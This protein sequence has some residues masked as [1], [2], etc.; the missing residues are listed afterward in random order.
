M[1]ILWFFL[2]IFSQQLMAENNNISMTKMQ[3]YNLG[4][5]TEQLKEI[6]QIPLLQVSAEVVVPPRQEFIISAPQLGLVNKLFVAIGDE[7]EKLQILATI[8]S[9]E[10]LTLQRQFLKTNGVKQLAWAAYKRDKQLFKEGVIADRQWQASRA[11]YAARLVEEDEAEQL[12]V[13]AGMS[14][15][16]IEQ[17]AA[18][19]QL[20]SQ[21]NIYSPVKGVVLERMVKMGE[22]LTM[23]TPLYRI[24]NLEQLW[25][26]IDVPQANIDGVQQGNRV[27]I[28]NT[29]MTATISLIGKNVNKQM[30]TVLV[31]AVIDSQQTNLRVGQRINVK[32]AQSSSE[33]VFIVPEAAIVNNKRQPYIFVRNEAGVRPTSIHI[34][35]EQEGGMIVTG[36]EVLSGDVNIVVRGAIALKAAWLG[37]NV[38]R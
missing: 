37:S 3:L 35:G 23:F 27:V 8:K 29:E 34:I 30:Q 7:V 25:L 13:I 33:K 14:G 4:V 15:K 36:G 10:L 28:E 6:S 17:L 21:L 19:H 32:I 18:S 1:K 16:E 2:Y 31:R 20:N 22:R 9:P 12:L 24:A 38:G 26:Y 5:K 11:L